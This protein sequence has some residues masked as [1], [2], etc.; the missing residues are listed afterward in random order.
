MSGNSAIDHDQVVESIK[1][2]TEEKG[3]PP[4][5]SELGKALGLV[6]RSSVLYWLRQLEEAGRIIREP[7]SPRSIRVL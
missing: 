5:M 1:T 4:T 6:S 2:L 3:Y 7:G